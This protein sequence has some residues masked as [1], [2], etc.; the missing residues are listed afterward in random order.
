MNRIA[1]SVL[2]LALSAATGIAFA[3][4]QEYGN[5]RHDHGY[6]DPR[7]Q[8]TVHTDRA[9]VLRVEQVGNPYGG[10]ST[11][12]REEC[13][14]E[15]TND[16]EGGYYRDGNGRLYRGDSR[17]NTQGLVIGALV[18]GALGNQVGKGDGRKAATIAGAVIGGAI[19]AHTGNNDRNDYQYR[20]DNSGVV[21]RCRTVV[22]T[23]DNNGGYGGY[24]GYN[25]T[26][27][28]AGQTYQAFTNQRPG[29]WIRVT[30]DV[31][32]QDYNDGYR[33]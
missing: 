3:G 1:M 19:G 31:R 18:G 30:V 2:T 16:Y 10:T 8:R 5:D 11:Y 6:N 25:V 4:A 23:T 7:S 9:Q 17:T 28:Y 21:R 32:P 22:T 12:E 27:A 33:H 13:W 14:N 15:Q 20:D 24:G 26:Y 29:R